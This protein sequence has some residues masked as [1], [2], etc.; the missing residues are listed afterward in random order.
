[1]RAND[2]I[3]SYREALKFVYDHIPEKLGKKFAG[4]FGYDRAA[5]L[6]SLLGNPQNKLKVIHVAGTSGKGST[7]FYISQLLASHGFNVSLTV[8]PHLIDIRERCQI[9]NRLIS[10]TEFTQTIKQI[11][12]KVVKMERSRY[13]KSS[14]FDV[15]VA[16][17]FQ[18]SLNNHVD[19]AVV[20]TGLGGLYDSTNTVMRGDKTCVIT[21]IGLDH[22]EILGKTLEKIAG[23]KAGIVQKNNTLITFRQPRSV[24]SA[25]EKRVR[26]Q[27]GKLIYVK[28]GLGEFRLG[29]P[30]LYQIENCSL[31][32]ATLYHLGK[33]DRF[34]IDKNKIRQTLLK[35][36]FPGRMDVFVRRGKT[37]IADG[38]HN[39]QKMASFM[40]SLKQVTTSKM[41]FL[42]AF[43]EGKNYQAMLEEIIPVASRIY[44]TNFVT[45]GTDLAIKSE[46]GK[47]VVDYLKKKKFFKTKFTADNKK[48]VEQLLKQKSKYAVVTGSLYLLSAIYSIIKS[49]VN[50]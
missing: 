24:R 37:V 38:A 4:Q 11:A 2:R 15:M 31:A 41:P 48:A 47:T 43:K 16:L 10:K 45:E 25:F 22:T 8:S 34:K 21:R 36:H 49:K 39:Q 20:E 42:V 35:S 50:S 1:M 26:E 46:N 33:R 17:F 32:L 3:G 27:R 9:N 7:V 13:G 5:H 28:D 30:A 12:P 44:V 23:Q 19:Y 14:Y 40:E 6:L 29:S 18:F